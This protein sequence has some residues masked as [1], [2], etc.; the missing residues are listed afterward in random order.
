MH[1]V[2][3]IVAAALLLALACGAC[4][5]A[6][7]QGFYLGAGAGLSKAQ[8]PADC[9]ADPG[10]TVT[11]CNVEDKKTGW[12]AFVGYQLNKN[13]AFEASYADLGK[14]KTSLT[15]SGIS[16]VKV[17]DHPTV[18]GID[19]IGIV[20]I[21]NEFGV[22]GRIGYFHFTLDAISTASVPLPGVTGDFNEKVDGSGVTFGVGA[23]WDFARNLGARLEYQRFPKIGNEDVGKSDVD[24]LSASLLY[25]F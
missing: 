2:Q 20:P 11:N 21:G 17:S 22:F 8:S 1:F 10:I 6:P 12:K 7:V 14:F 16:D 13:L 19:V 15:I 9:S 24:L 25:R 4:A 5:Q 23:T 18:Y 3:R